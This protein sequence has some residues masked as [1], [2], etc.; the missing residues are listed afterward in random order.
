MLHR[1]LPL[2]YRPD[3]GLDFLKL[4]SHE[5]LEVLVDILIHDKGTSRIA[6]QLSKEPEFVSNRNDLTK[7]WQL[8]AS[9][10][11]RFGADS[12]ASAWRGGKGTTYRDMLGAV[13]SRFKVQHDDQ[14][15]FA[16]IEKRLLSKVFEQA[17]SKMTEEERKAFANEL[18]KTTN[19]AQFDAAKAAPGALLGAMQ[20]AVQLGGFAA[21]QINMM[22][23]NS[24][25]KAVLGH[26]L[27]LATNASLNR[28]L[29]I[30]A[31]PAGWVLTALMTVQL[32]TGPA[33]RVV[34]PATFYVA[35]LRQKLKQ[36]GRKPRKVAARK[37]KTRVR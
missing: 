7:C 36:P 13:A 2:V 25:A 32:V 18:H 31:G 4:A 5:D 19:L 20:A 9:E 3:R 12:I 21:Y 34:I 22:I 37:S 23:V 35:T 28:M 27:K 17:V 24:V 26:G 33:Y 1:I 30:A 10:F 6:E 8:I 11:Q 16:R 29:S 15:A 14:E